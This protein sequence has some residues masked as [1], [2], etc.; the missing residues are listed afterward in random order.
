MGD[1]RFQTVRTLIVHRHLKNRLIY[2]DVIF[3]IPYFVYKGFTPIL[4]MQYYFILK[5]MLG[6]FLIEIHGYRLTHVCVTL[7]SSHQFVVFICKWGFVLHQNGDSSLTECRQREDAFWKKLKWIGSKIFD[8]D[9]SSWQFS[10][11]R[12]SWRT[13]EWPEGRGPAWPAA[14]SSDACTGNAAIL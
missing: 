12:R 8:L 6:T 3:L 1:D 9:Q 5:L 11:W 13:R 10:C 7:C 4:S 14:A 2:K